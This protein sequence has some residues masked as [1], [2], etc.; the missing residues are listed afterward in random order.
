MGFISL[1][2]IVFLQNTTLETNRHLLPIAQLPEKLVGMRI[3][4]LSDLHLTQSWIETDRIIAA[5]AK[6]KPDLIVL[7][8]DIIDRSAIVE[9]S[10]LATLA[11]QL[12]HIAPVFAVSGN[13]ETSSG[14]LKQW[15]EVLTSA[16]V[17]VL[18]NRG[19]IFYYNQQ[20][21]LIVGLANPYSTDKVK[22]SND[23]KGLTTLL[24]A[25]RPEKF[26]RYLTD[27]ADIRPDLVF[28]G[29]THGGQICLPI[30]GAIFVPDQALFPKYSAGIYQ[31]PAEKGA[32]GTAEKIHYLV[33]N[34]GIGNTGSAIP[35]RINSVPEIIVVDLVQ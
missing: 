1:L 20:P 9:R 13:H 12:Q 11:R 34:R 8:G 22:L 10:D 18:N 19:E 21:L 4:H 32:D 14:Q 15:Q 29:H 25:H 30:I 16:G 31:H 7:T 27:N 17:T 28:S 33:L 6:T 26:E 3:A 24:L 5:V 2:C 23:Q 35:L